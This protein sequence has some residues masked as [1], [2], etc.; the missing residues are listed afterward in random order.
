M[1]QSCGVKSSYMG[2][3]RPFINDEK[4]YWIMNPSIFSPSFLSRKSICTRRQVWGH[5]WCGVW[6]LS[7]LRDNDIYRSI[8]TKE[9]IPVIVIWVCFSWCHRERTHWFCSYSDLESPDTCERAQLTR[10]W[11]KVMLRFKKQYIVR[12][13]PS[14]SATNRSS[15]EG[16]RFN[17]IWSSFIYYLLTFQ[18]DIM[19]VRVCANC[20]SAFSA[21]SGTDIVIFQVHSITPD[22]GVILMGS[23]LLPG[24]LNNNIHIR[25]SFHSRGEA[26]WGIYRKITY[27]KRHSLHNTHISH[28]DSYLF[29]S[30]ENWYCLVEWTIA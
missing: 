21:S 7:W 22:L 23:L 1:R 8:S 12:L 14:K 20:S 25:S 18:S 26:V 13:C 5:Y 2:I 17:Y 15:W 24:E 19:Q 11:A 4:K 6:L 9:D 29:T 16:S 28:A 27:T 30:S 10:W 3:A